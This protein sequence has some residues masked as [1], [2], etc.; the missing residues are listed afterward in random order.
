MGGQLAVIAAV[1]V[2][3]IMPVGRISISRAR[4]ELSKAAEVL[5]IRILPV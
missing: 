3:K 2:I 5:Q 1:F 4:E